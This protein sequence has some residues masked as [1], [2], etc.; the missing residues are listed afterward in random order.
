MGW[1]RSILSVA[2]IAAACG[3]DT[4]NTISPTS[5]TSQTSTEFFAITVPVQSSRFYAFSL[6]EAGTVE[7]TLVRV[8]PDDGKSTLTTR[9]GLGNGT[10]NGTDCDLTNTVVTPPGLTAQLKIPLGVGT[11]CAKVFDVGEL[12]TPVNVMVRIVHP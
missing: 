2:V 9:M 11:H 3:G 8:S 12:R 5:V 1:R 4:G 6:L 10:P 7:I